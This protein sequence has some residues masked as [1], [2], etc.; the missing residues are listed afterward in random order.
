MWLFTCTSV[1]DPKTGN[2]TETYLAKG[3]TGGCNNFMVGLS[4]M[5]S[6]ACRAG[7]SVDDIAD[8]LKSSG[9]CPSYAVR[10][11]TKN[12]TSVGSSCPVAIAYALLEMQKEAW[13]EMNRDEKEEQPN[14]ADTSVKCPECGGK[15]LV[16]AE[17][18]ITCSMCGWSRCS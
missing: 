2:L 15:D 11:A 16:R 7:V 17:G 6:L 3:S 13:A 8:Q 1:F 10:R 12:D 9:T 4:R 5:L 18:C 14:D